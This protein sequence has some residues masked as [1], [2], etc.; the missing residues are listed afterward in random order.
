MRAVYVWE[1]VGDLGHRDRGE[2]RRVGGTIFT[3]RNS[4]ELSVSFT[5]SLGDDV[6][7]GGWLLQM[8]SQPAGDT[9]NG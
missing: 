2:G 9:T 5:D 4:I 3:S 7:V 8:T 6:W 1:R